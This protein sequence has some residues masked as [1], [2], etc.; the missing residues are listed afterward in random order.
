MAVVR[1]RQM[2]VGLLSLLLTGL[3][4]GA[5]GAD[6]TV[7]PAPTTVAPVA[8]L[9]PT[10]AVPTTAAAITTV[11]PT[12]ALATTVAPTT[13]APTTLAPTPTPNS[14]PTIPPTFTVGPT[15]VPQPSAKG[16]W[17][18]G[19]CYEV[20]VRSFFDSNGD[21]IGDFPGLSARLD[22]IKNLGANCIWLMPITQS[23]SYHGYDTTDFYTINK[24]Y[25]TNDDFKK[26]M[27][28]AH[29]R[30]IYVLM[31]I[32]LN[33]T[34]DQ[35][36]WFKEAQNP[37]SPKRNW[38]IWNP[39]DPKYQGP[40]GAQAWWPK[41][42]EFYY[43]L[44]G[45][46]LPD[47]NY[48]NPDVT[49]EMYNVTRFWLQEMGVDGFRV[50]AV[51][52]LI[53]DQRVQANTPETKAWLRDW[54]KYYKSLKPDAFAVGEINQAGGSDELN[55][56]WPD[57][58]DSYFEFGLAEGIIR[59]ITS[60]NPNRLAQALTYSTKN[61]PYQRWSS[62]LTNHDQNRIMSRLQ[63]DVPQMKLAATTLLTVPGLPFIY[64]GE[65]L[66]AEGKKPDEN[67]RTPMQWENNPGA[68]FTTG[69]PW[70]KP[71]A[72]LA[73][74][75]V[76]A[77]D[78][79]PN[80]LLNLYRK[81]AKLRRESSALSEGE[82]TPLVSTKDTVGAFLRTSPA[83]NML[84]I[85]NFDAKAV[86]NPAFS[87]EESKLKLKPGQYS[88]QE[89]LQGATVSEITVGDDGLLKSASPL[90]KLEPY[91]GYIIRLKSK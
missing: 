18:N 91:T 49:K 7:T 66:G 85:L 47:L 87:L 68:G 19:V 81:L 63:G 5:C 44:F 42:N 56:Y 76:V 45:G 6:P 64:Y 60:N 86:D 4:W 30:G 52:H 8:T 29:N 54:A 70:R 40:W 57:Q 89:L 1:F 37:S 36:P 20:F 71:D 25:G 39:T 78:K 67:I 46:D 83:E 55:G 79:D 12:T 69:T 10:T 75:N 73:T 48:R 77:E 72:S 33:H 43:G 28:E 65:E 90:A 62:F 31:D 14:G 15:P 51:K 9:A 82:W 61:W 3:I 2:L 80:S 59:S 11:A 34:S 21:G 50:D 88:A 35:H 84:V 32:V 27:Q 17:T 16:W 26:F 38:Y 74:A 24:D 22:Y 58:L 13:A 53:E 41:N 23:P